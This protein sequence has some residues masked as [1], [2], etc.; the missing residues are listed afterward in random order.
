MIMPI[1]MVGCGGLWRKQP[2]KSINKFYGYRTAR[3]MKSKESWDFAH[4]YIG[5]IWFKL[6]VGIAIFT[7]II[8]F[9]F[10]NSNDST[11]GKVF[12]NLMIIQIITLIVPIISTE[13]A[14][15]RKFEK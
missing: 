7:I 10:K 3:S 11:L 4:K 5:R 12:V 6:G 13:I 8:F 15:K 2:P 14:L 9:I 1:V